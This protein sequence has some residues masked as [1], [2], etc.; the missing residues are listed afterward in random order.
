MA[1]YR[2]CRDELGLELKL[3]HSNYLLA[4]LTASTDVS[5]LWRELASLGLVR[6]APA[7]PLNFFSPDEPNVFF[8]S[9]SC[10]SPI[11]SDSDL[12]RALAMPLNGQLVFEFANISSE[13]VSLTI[14]ST[15]TP[16]CS[17]GPD[18]VSNFCIH[19]AL[20]KLAS[21]LASLFNTSLITGHFP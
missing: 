7:S 14:V 10:I 11:C 4:R 21:L 3:A 17:T 15:T 2:Q 19:S 6:P 12:A 1:I 18:G 20:P 9:F 5:R 16:S 8:D 13:I